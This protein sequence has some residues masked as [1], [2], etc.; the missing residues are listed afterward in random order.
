MTDHPDS[1][2]SSA[3]NR[4]TFIAG[5]A[6]AAVAPLTARGAAAQPSRQQLKIHHSR[7]A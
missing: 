3:F 4:R 1:P 5:A 7:S 2:I 6:G